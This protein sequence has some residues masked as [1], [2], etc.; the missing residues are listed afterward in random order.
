MRR[1]GDA[2]S[3]IVPRRSGSLM[4]VRRGAWPRRGSRISGREEAST[5]SAAPRV[6]S[7]PIR[8]PSRRSRAISRA[9][10]HRLL[11]DLRLAPRDCRTQLFRTA[12]VIA[13]HPHQPRPRM[14]P[15]VVG[16]RDRTI[17]ARPDDVLTHSRTPVPQRYWC[18]R[19]CKS[20]SEECGVARAGWNVPIGRVGNDDAARRGSEVLNPVE[21]AAERGSERRRH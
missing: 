14:T 4:C 20:S 9:Q 13:H 21:C 16:E 7:V 15:K 8:R 6:K 19:V 2:N 11:E 1:R 12:I 10:L 18:R 5:A 3:L 17:D